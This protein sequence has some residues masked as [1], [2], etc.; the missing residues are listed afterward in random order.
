MTD[1]PAGL[2]H[3]GIVSH[4][5]H[6]APLYR[7]TY[8]I[9]MLSLDLDHIDALGLRLFCH[10]R[11]GVV[12]LRDRDHGARNGAPLRPWVETQLRRAGLIDCDA[13]IRFMMIPRVFGYAFNPIAFFFCYD[14]LGRLGAV[15]HQVKNTF[16]GQQPYVLPVAP[17]EGL[18]RQTSHKRMHVSPFFDMQGG[19]RFAFNRPDFT[20]GGKFA[21]SI[22]Y[23]TPQ[24]ARMTATMR[25]RT[26][27]LTDSA[28]LRQLL[29]S[30]MMP[31]KVTAAIHWQALKIW[32]GGGRYHPAPTHSEE[33]A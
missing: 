27:E 29:V 11:R 19:Y 18:V 2:L 17:G 33:P 22:R 9:W 24:A 31:L 16:G 32:L 7:F 13:R 25:L 1:L 26:D 30:P 5:R 8:R 15:L 21:L 12:S 3:T 23:G 6:V 28:L 10:N 14:Q 4:R 20:P